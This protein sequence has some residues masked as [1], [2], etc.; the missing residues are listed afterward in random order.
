[1]SWTW[2]PLFRWILLCLVSDL[3]AD[4]EN[5]IEVGASGTCTTNKELLYIIGP[6]GIGKSTL[7][8]FINGK[9]TCDNCR[10]S[11]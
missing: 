5:E 1:M 2:C 4:W 9:D 3:N 11:F 8:N 7:G 10:N 6:T